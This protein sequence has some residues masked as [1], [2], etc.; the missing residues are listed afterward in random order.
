MRVSQFLWQILR[1]AITLTT[2]GVAVWVVAFM[3][4]DYLLNPWTRNGQV[5]A[6]IVTMTPRVTGPI[7]E[8][9]IK[10]N[11]SV[12]KGDLLFR[13]DP[14]T[15]QDAVEADEAMLEQAVAARAEAQD[16]VNRARS[17]HK[18]DPGAVS[19]LTLVQKENDLLSAKGVVR[20]ARA[21]LHSAKLN[22]TFTRVVAP[23]DGF[24]THL[25]ID[26]GSHVVANQPVLALVD[27]DS[28]WVVGFFKETQIEHIH[29]GDKA[30][31]KLMAYPDKPIEGVVN[32]LGW[33]IAT[34]DGTPASDDL[35]PQINP[36]FDW[37]RL[38]Q[39]VPVRIHPTEIPPGVQLRVGTTATVIVLHDDDP[40]KRKK[41]WIRDLLRA[42]KH[43]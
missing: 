27:S 30:I 15:F 14:R 32:S 10:D 5:D 23:V 13:I 4:R 1:I 8:L 43:P 19:K 38:A 22:L 25:Q 41:Q 12:R 28:F 24:V 42:D 35:L 36:S 16:Q 11:Q 20:G 39:R 18:R 6:Y 9:P 33:G 21:D 7:V 3:F 26:I 34:Q 29:P 31:V 37:I 17:L 40:A 2:V